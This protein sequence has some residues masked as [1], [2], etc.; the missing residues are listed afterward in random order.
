MPEIF[1]MWTVSMVSFPTEECGH[2]SSVQIT[3][4]VISTPYKRP[5]AASNYVTYRFKSQI[6]LSE[7]MPQAPLAKNVIV[8]SQNLPE[9]QGEYKHP[10]VIIFLILIPY[11]S[12]KELY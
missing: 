2:V 8:Q 9:S 4:P 6:T 11:Q 1:Q 12:T 7:K 10:M 3:S 5:D